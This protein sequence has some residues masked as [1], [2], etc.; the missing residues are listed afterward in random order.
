[1][2]KAKLEVNDRDLATDMGY[3]Y[4]RKKSGTLSFF[5]DQRGQEIITIDPM[6]GDVDLTVVGFPEEEY[7][8]VG[9]GN[10][11]LPKFN[12]TRQFSNGRF[13]HAL[14]IDCKN[15][16]QYGYVLQIH[17]DLTVRK[18]A[19]LYLNSEWITI[20]RDDI[21]YEIKDNYVTQKTYYSCY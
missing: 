9:A 17:V 10:V 11:S 7:Y 16:S 15:C 2:C 19:G 4:R 13:M 14:S 21:M 20:E 8:I 18:V 3:E 5:I 1:M 6:N 12:K